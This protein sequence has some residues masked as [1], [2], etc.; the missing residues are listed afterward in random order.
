MDVVTGK[1]PI[2]GLCFVFKSKKNNT[3]KN[4][5]AK[6]IFL[7]YKITAT[8]IQMKVPQVFI[9]SLSAWDWVKGLHPNGK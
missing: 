8:D 6:K 9:N 7:R 3:I 2:I 4:H 1:L 5:K